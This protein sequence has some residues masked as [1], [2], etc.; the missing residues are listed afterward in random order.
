[1]LLITMI[2]PRDAADLV[3][4]APVSNKLIALLAALAITLGALVSYLF[5]FGMRDT[6]VNRPM[7]LLIEHPMAHL[8]MKG[9]PFFVFVYAGAYIG[10]W[11]GGKAT[12]RD[13]YKI[14]VWTEFFM[15]AV[16]FTQLV[17]TYSIPFPT[18]LITA[19]LTGYAY[20]I[21][22]SFIAEAHGFKSELRVFAFMFACVIAMALLAALALMPFAE[23]S[24]NPGPNA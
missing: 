19:L 17:V 23:F 21:L 15:V 9:I 4:K 5:Y 10:S 7:S 18:Q 6:V 2:K 22:A 24:V 12:V 14:G 13:F 20:F 3:L 8:A 1:M 11:F 16:N